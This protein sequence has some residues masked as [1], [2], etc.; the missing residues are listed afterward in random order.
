[1]FLTVLFLFFSQVEAREVSFSWEPFENVL[2]YQIEVSDD[3]KFEKEPTIKKVIKNPTLTVDLA[4]GTYYYRVRAVDQQKRPGHWSEPEKVIV[5]PY[6]PELTLPKNV[7]E[8]TYFEIPPP[9]QFTW[10]PTEGEPVYELFVYK[11][12]GKKILEKKTKEPKLL[13][14]ELTEGEYMWKVRT[15]YKDIYTSPYCEPRRFLIEKKPLTEPKVVE[16]NN[17]LVLP[18]YRPVDMVW[19]KDSSTHFTD[20]KVETV[21]KNKKVVLLEQNIEESNEHTHIFEESGRYQWSVTTKEGEKTTGL[22]SDVGT[23]E[24]R[25]DL[26]ADENYSMEFGFSPLM[27]QFDYN[28]IRG[29]NGTGSVDGTAFLTNLKGSYFLTREYGLRLDLRKGTLAASNDVPFHDWSLSNSLRMGASGFTQEFLIGYRQMNLF[30]FLGNRY[31]LFT[32]NGAQVGTQIRVTASRNWRVR[33][34]ANYFKPIYYMERQ[35]ELKADIYEGYLGV[36]W[37]PFYKF[38]VN[39]QFGYSKHVISFKPEGSLSDSKTS[40]VI[41]EPFYITISLEH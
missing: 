35:G 7:V 1:M 2:G 13:V 24:L 33:F 28:D 23:F 19:T 6:P 9:I 40:A 5:T 30:E 41:L 27:A 16:P 17:N 32:T 25:N 4:M 38:W 31:N 34:S 29:G 22:S 15:I 8:F 21:G 18:A 3:M 20:L 10:K 39:Y 12:T 36:G 14:K 26:I 11:T 37:N